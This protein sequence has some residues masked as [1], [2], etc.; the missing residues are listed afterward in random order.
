MMMFSRPAFV[1]PGFLNPHE[2][3][4]FYVR[5]HYP[6]EQSV[7]GLTDCLLLLLMSGYPTSSSQCMGNRLRAMQCRTPDPMF[8]LPIQAAC[9][10]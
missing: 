2:Q 6:I 4:G 3:Q 1:H 5:Y 9:Y 8:R 10:P 7:R